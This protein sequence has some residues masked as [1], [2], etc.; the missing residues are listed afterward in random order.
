MNYENAAMYQREAIQQ[1][2]QPVKAQY[3]EGSKEVT[4]HL[5]GGGVAIIPIEVIHSTVRKPA[6]G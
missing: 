5:G 6:A 3:K 2:L 4:V 1:D